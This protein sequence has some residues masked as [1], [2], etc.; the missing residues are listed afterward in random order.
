VPA[1][2]QQDTSLCIL[3]FGGCGDG[4]PES[5]ARNDQAFARLLAVCQGRGARV[6]LPAGRYPLSE[7]LSLV[8]QRNLRFIGEGGNPKQPGTQ[9]VAQHSTGSLIDLA[10]SV[11]CGFEGI[12]FD[13]ANGPTDP[14]VQLRCNTDGPDGLSTLAIQ[15]TDCVFSATKDGTGIAMRDSAN[16]DF[17]Q[18]WFMG[19]QTAVTLG[20]PIQ[21]G[22]KSVSNGL[23]NTVAF[24]TC[25][26]F[27]SLRGIRGSAIRVSNCMFSAC[28]DGTG[29]GLDF[30]GDPASRIT[31]VTITGCFAIEAKGGVFFRQGAQGFGLNFENNRIAGYDTGITLDGQGGAVIR[32]N[33]FERIDKVL[34]VENPKG[35]YVAEANSG[36]E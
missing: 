22:A 2:A 13:G 20:V 26:F 4:T 5:A 32:A 1:A 11:H 21:S 35:S 14:V 36:L 30:G 9:L 33:L 23:V 27:A 31:N 19:G 7:P 29:A 3:Q 24:D 6:F 10:S 17:H 12:H 34:D 25:L 8:R 16:I 15:F 18:C 28:P